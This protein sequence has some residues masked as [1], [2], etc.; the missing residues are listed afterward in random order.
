MTVDI[1]TL[2]TV[3]ASTGVLAAIGTGIRGLIRHVTGRERR[4]QL[5]TARLK[6]ERDR[7]WRRRV[8]MADLYA[9]ARHIAAEAGADPAELEALDQK[10]DDLLEGQSND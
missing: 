6:S 10:V 9:R 2:V 8:K 3:L 4:E 5:S 7:E 1:Q